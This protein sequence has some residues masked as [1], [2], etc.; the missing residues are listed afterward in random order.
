MM[1][2]MVAF[3]S[4]LMVALLFSNYT[5]IYKIHADHLVDTSVIIMIG[6]K[7]TARVLF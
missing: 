2:M 5:N 6:Q 1:P 4:G 7:Y 3:S